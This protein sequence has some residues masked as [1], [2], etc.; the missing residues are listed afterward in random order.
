MGGVAAYIEHLLNNGDCV[1]V[2]IKYGP[3]GN[4]YAVIPY[5]SSYACGVGAAHA[6][7]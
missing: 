2:K 6:A 4:I 5:V 7:H 1:G 3:G